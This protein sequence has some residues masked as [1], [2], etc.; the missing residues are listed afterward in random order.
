MTVAEQLLALL[1]RAAPVLV[2]RRVRRL[3]MPP[4]AAADTLAGE[5]CALELESGAVGLSYVLLDGLLARMTE[6]AAALERLEGVDALELARDYL[7]PAPMK[8]TLGF[9]AINALT[10]ALFDRAGFVVP[11]SADS[12]GLLNPERGDHV[13]MIGYFKRLIPRVIAT[14]ARLTIVELRADLAGSHD[15]FRVTLDPAELATCNKV[16]STSTLLLNHTLDRMLAACSAARQFAMVGPGAS[17]LPDPLFARGVTVL[18][19]TWINDVPEFCRALVAGES[20]EPHAHKVA[21][22]RADYPGFEVLLE[23]A[24]GGG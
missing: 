10:R 20:W 2:P 7:D 3:H 11:A 19:G 6:Q 14:G 12:T 23:R 4:L 9:A 18:G 5:F 13:G 15:G 8:R 24:R 21:L 22:R 17:C 16:L 1:E